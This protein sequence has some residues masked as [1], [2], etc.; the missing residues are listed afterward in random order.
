MKKQS[1]AKAGKAE[2]ITIIMFYGEECPHCHAMMPS[3][4]RLEKE[5]GV[6][7]EKLEVWHNERNADEMRKYIDIITKASGGTFGTPTFMDKKRTRALVGEVSYEE[8]KKW[9]LGR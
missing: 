4:D 1:D 9:A 5:E 2:A 3:V 7:V 6:R 8:L